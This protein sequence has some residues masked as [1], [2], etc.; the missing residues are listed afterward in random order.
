MCTLSQPQKLNKKKKSKSENLPWDKNISCPGVVR[1]LLF[2]VP[3]SVC[4]FPVWCNEGP[5][6]GTSGGAGSGGLSPFKSVGKIGDEIFRKKKKYKLKGT[7]L[8]T[9][10]SIK[11]I[12][13]ASGSEEAKFVFYYY[14][15]R[16]FPPPIKNS[17]VGIKNPFIVTCVDN[18]VSH[19][20]EAFFFYIQNL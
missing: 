13:S 16:Y 3:R 8:F 4:V 14:R 6:G 9:V 7:L 20:P 10:K 17:Q 2:L 5:R 15:F 11:R 1:S 18:W 19:F 12:K